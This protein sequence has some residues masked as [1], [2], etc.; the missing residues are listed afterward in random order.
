MCVHFAESQFTGW[1]TLVN[2]HLLLKS[3][4]AAASTIGEQFLHELSSVFCKT[5]MILQEDSKNIVKMSH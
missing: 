3:F 5:E 2:K 1:D 4:Q